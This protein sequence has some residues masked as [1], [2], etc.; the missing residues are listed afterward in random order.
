[1]V[2]KLDRCEVGAIVTTALETAGR[3]RVDEFIQS[4]PFGPA[5]VVVLAG[6]V[7][8]DNFCP[9]VCLCLNSLRYEIHLVPDRRREGKMSWLRGVSRGGR[10]LVEGAV[11]Q[12]CRVVYKIEGPNSAVSACSY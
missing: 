5:T 7:F 1:M 9:N 12:D 3:S 8:D 4:Y 6:M 2:R 10:C 11:L